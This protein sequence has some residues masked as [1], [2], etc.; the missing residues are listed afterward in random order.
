MLSALVMEG[1][2]QMV[3]A[4]AESKHAAGFSLFFGGAGTQTHDPAHGGE[5]I[6]SALYLVVNTP[7]SITT[8]QN[9]LD[10]PHYPLTAQACNT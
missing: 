10:P 6:T 9:I 2:K 7:G 5:V 4:F 1:G 3:T 8:I